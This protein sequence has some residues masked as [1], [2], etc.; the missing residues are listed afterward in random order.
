[1]FFFGLVILITRLGQNEAAKLLADGHH[2][3]ERPSRKQIKV[4]FQ[5]HEGQTQYRTQS[6]VDLVG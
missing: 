3:Y 4:L 6:E 2:G 5:T 1:M